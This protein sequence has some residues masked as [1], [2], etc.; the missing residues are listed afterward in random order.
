MKKV[1]VKIVVAALLLTSCSCM[2]M[3]EMLEESVQ[4]NMPEEERFHAMSEKFQVVSVC[5]MNYEE[6]GIAAKL[7][8]EG[9]DEQW[10]FPQIVSDVDKRGMAE[11][12]HRVLQKEPQ[13]LKYTTTCARPG[14]SIRLYRAG[15]FS[16][17]NTRYRII[18]VL[19]ETGNGT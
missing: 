13:G 11:T 4:S 7:R 19:E 15:F 16:G 3:D 6:V 10:T 9:G 14:R 17:E 8:C 12:A 5:F 1:S 2:D 18:V